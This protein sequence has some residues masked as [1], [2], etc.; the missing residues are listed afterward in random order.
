MNIKDIQDTTVGTSIEVLA[1]VKDIEKKIKANNE[2]FIMLTV[3]DKTGDISFPVWEHVEARL[4]ILEE[5]MVI[6]I[7]GVV[8]EYNNTKQIRVNGMMKVE[9]ANILDFIPSYD[10]DNNFYSRVEEILRVISILKEPYK[11]FTL[12]YLGIEDIYTGNYGDNFVDIPKD[13]KMYELMYCPAAVHHHQNKVGGLLLHTTGVLRNANS[14]ID[15]YIYTPFDALSNGIVNKDR[16]LMCAILHDIEKIQEYTWK[17]F[18]TKKKTRFDHRLLFVKESEKLN[19]KG[20]FFSDEELIEIQEIILTHHGMWSA[21]KPKTLEQMILFTADLI[22]ANVSECVEND[23][24]KVDM[25]LGRM[26]DAE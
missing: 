23:T 16:L 2:P 24:T 26:I 9:D 11:S 18:I 13:S 22:D 1:L 4:G 5:G 20:K 10:F 17:P 8:G 3:S 12:E 21:H 19:E 15:N 6:K 25:K 14:L 7:L